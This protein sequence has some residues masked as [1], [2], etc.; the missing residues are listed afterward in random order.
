MKTLS[1]NV[2]NIGIIGIVPAREL[3]TQ[4]I[5]PSHVPILILPLS[6]SCQTVPF[7]PSLKIMLIEEHLK[8]CWDLGCLYSFIFILFYSYFFEMK[9][10]SVA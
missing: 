4:I 2:Q 7:L 6:L 9:L 3:T 5:V 10:N 1:I 8:I